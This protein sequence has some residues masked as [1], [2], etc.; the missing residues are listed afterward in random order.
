MLQ[1]EGSIANRKNESKDV[2]KVLHGAPPTP[3]P[4]RR[5]PDRFP[6]TVPGSELQQQQQQQGA[7]SPGP[8]GAGLRISSSGIQL[9]PISHMRY[10]LEDPPLAG[11]GEFSPNGAKG[12]GPRWAGGGRSP[13]PPAAAGGPLAGWSLEGPAGGKLLPPLDTA[14]GGQVGAVGNQGGQEQGR[15]SSMHN[16]CDHGAA[17]CST[18]ASTYHMH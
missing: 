10:S 16:S 15:M 8:P 11:Q 2:W 13:G 12:W 7:W 18:W 17:A 5:D 14:G 1:T 4:Q 6:Q 9:Q 3:P